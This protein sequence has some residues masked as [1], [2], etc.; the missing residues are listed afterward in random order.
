MRFTY[1]YWDSSGAQK[2]ATL[3]A[4]DRAAALQA[5]RAA[6]RVPILLRQGGSSVSRARASLLPAWLDRRMATLLVLLAILLGVGMLL[7]RNTPAAPAAPAAPATPAAPTALAASAAPASPTALTATPTRSVTHHTPHPASPADAP[8]R[9]DAVAQTALAA[10]KEPAA[11]KPPKRPTPFKTATEQLLAMITSAPPGSQMPPLPA[12]H[13]LENDF[14]RASTNTLEIFDTDS[15]KLAKTIETVAWAKVDLK[16]LVKQGWEP[17]EVLQEMARQH[18]E[19]ATL[20][21]SA[22]LLLKKLVDENSLSAAALREELTLINAE[23]IERG[24]PEITYPE[25]GLIE[26]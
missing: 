24:L 3:E 1:S 11:S 13:G 12:L 15:K 17:D 22:A 10:Q 8:S 2:E 9:A 16:E 5:I 23:L 18:N 21:T 7:R 19:E 25:L 4:A 20:R 26:G 14:A 6:G